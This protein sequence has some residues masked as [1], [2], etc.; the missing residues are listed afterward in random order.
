[1]LASGPELARDGKMSPA[2]AASSMVEQ[3]TLNQLVEGSSPSRLTSMSRTNKPFG[4]I[5]KGFRLGSY[6]SS[7]PRALVGGDSVTVKCFS[8]DTF[9]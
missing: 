2:W 5:P 7:Y 3:L 1:M 8:W 9:G 6:P 4:L